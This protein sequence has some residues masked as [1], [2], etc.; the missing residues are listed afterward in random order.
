M[1]GNRSFWEFFPEGEGSTEYRVTSTERT[2]LWDVPISADARSI[3]CG[4]IASRFIP[5]IGMTQVECLGGFA[6]RC[7]LEW[8]SLRFLRRGAV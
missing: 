5:S 7:V 3:D 1:S 2:H 4:M 6:C 8:R